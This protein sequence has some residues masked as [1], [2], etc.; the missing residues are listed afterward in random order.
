MTSAVKKEMEKNL[1][2]FHKL[3]HK[4]FFFLFMM[5]DLVLYSRF[6]FFFQ[7]SFIS[8][9]GRRFNLNYFLNL[10]AYKMVAPFLVYY[11]QNDNKLNINEENYDDIIK[12]IDSVMD[13]KLG[14]YKDQLELKNYESYCKNTLEIQE[15]YILSNLNLKKDA[16]KDLLTYCVNNKPLT[17]TNL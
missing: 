13:Q 10:Q 3:N 11:S 12:A 1:N 4:K 6:S 15:D 17:L 9:T 14:L 5:N 8:Y 2:Y 16:F 7:G